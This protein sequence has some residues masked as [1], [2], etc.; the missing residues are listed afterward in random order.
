MSVDKYVICVLLII[1]KKFIIGLSQKRPL[2]RKAWCW[3][4]KCCV[5]KAGFFWGGGQTAS[6]N[7]GVKL[8]AFMRKIFEFHEDS[9]LVGLLLLLM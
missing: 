2:W 9:Y 8:L 6:G 1:N 4:R 3:S 7:F 5:K